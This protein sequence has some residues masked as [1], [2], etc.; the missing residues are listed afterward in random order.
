MLA[1]RVGQDQI[2][3]HNA[4]GKAR[5]ALYSY[6]SP[7]EFDRVAH[8]STAPE[9]WGKFLATM[10][11]QPKSKPDSSTRIDMSMKTLPK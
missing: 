8:L 10:R 2:D 5:N 7:T 1:A 6:L 3:Q 9:I 11:V 4:N